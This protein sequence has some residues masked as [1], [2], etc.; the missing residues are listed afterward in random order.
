MLFYCFE[1]WL[2]VILQEQGIA[3]TQSGWM[4]SLVQFAQLPIVL[5]VP[6][7]ADKMK[8]QRI[9][10]W[11]TF[12]MIIIGL[13]GIFYIGNTYIGLFVV[14]FGMGAGVAFALSMMFFNLRS[15]SVEQATA[16][17]G[18]AQSI[19]YLLAASGPLLLG[20]L[21]DM[22]SR[23]DISAIFLI[24]ATIFLLVTGLGAAKERYV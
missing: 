7:L 3:L 22:T 14:L 19:G 16:V 12:Y 15:K 6:I 4:L 18:M 17:S 24:I 9:L 20:L 23:W 10:V 13:V 2:P 11:I 8:D 5:I 1:A 21:Y